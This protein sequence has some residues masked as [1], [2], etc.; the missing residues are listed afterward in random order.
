LKGFE[1]MRSVLTIAV[2]ASFLSGCAL[3][4]VVDTAVSITSTVVSTT[5]DVAAGAV[6]AVAGSSHDEKEPKD[7]REQS[8][9]KAED[10]GASKDSSSDSDE[11]CESK[12][13]KDK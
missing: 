6:S 12:A 10:K 9:T 3:V 7:C 8:E 2:L 11:E 5:V 13:D 1:A 4:S